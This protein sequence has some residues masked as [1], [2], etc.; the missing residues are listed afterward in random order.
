MANSA[1]NINLSAKD[2]D[3][4]TKLPNMQRFRDI[5]AYA[6]EQD[7][8]IEFGN[9][10]SP[11][12]KACLMLA[13]MEAK[14]AMEMIGAP[15]INDEFLQ[16]VKDEKLKGALLIVKNK[17]QTQQQSKS[18]PQSPAPAPQTEYEKSRE[19]RRRTL[20]A[21]EKSG[22]ISKMEKAELEYIHATILK[23]A[24]LEKAI[25]K[26]KSED[27]RF[28]EHQQKSGLK[29]EDFYYSSKTRT[30]DADWK[31]HLDVVPNRN[32]PTTKAISEML[33]HLDIEHKIAKGGDNGK[34]MT[35]YVG[36]YN[37][38]LRLSKEINSR[39]GKEIETSPCYVDQNLS[40]HYFNPKVS[41]RFWMQNIFK[42]QYPRSSAFGI[43]PATG[44]KNKEMEAFEAEY[45]IFDLGQ[46]N[47]II[48]AE[49]KFSDGSYNLRFFNN[50]DFHKS[51]VF[52]NLEAYC[53]H[54]L[55]Q[56]ELG[57]FYCGKDA[58]KFEKDFFG[59][60]IPEKGT[61]ERANWD[62][63]A[64]EYVAF[65]ENMHPNLMQKMRQEA[66]RYHSVDFSKLPPLPQNT[67]VHGGGRSA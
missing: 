47:D 43:C 2:K 33:K 39:F 20:E 30:S 9:I 10:K 23:N 36:N 8:Q 59:D 64:Q 54:K 12:F 5:V 17:L 65:I 29:T 51:Y 11:E 34:G 49:D 25:Q 48:P 45:R 62:K 14:P 38:T 1:S 3:G 41:G 67:Q 16:T 66:Q 21:K 58:D 22:K 31:L 44:T 6:R 37:D 4:N 24:E 13:C 61:M 32:H 53:S 19:I 7:T 15:D 55:Y 27:P 28:T 18:N 50:G 52:H 56:K 35:I 63:V 26:Y 60:K 40:E 46:K 57:E 42:T